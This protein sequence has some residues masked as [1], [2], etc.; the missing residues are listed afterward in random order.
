[1]DDTHLSPRMVGW[2]A[3]SGLSASD[4]EDS[5]LALPAARGRSRLVRV[6][7]QRGGDLDLSA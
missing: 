3:V 2:V 1:M 4:Y 5:Q 7:V 6:S